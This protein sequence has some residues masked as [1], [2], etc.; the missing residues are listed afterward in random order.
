M[1]VYVHVCMRACAYMHMY[2]YVRLRI[3]VC[4]YACVYL[5]LFICMYV[6]SFFS[7]P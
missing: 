7:H 1:S 2:V 4:F 3:N 5:Y 6:F